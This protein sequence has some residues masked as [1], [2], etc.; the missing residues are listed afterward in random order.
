MESLNKL[1][2]PI[3]IKAGKTLTADVKRLPHLLIAGGGT[4]VARTYLSSMLIDAAKEKSPDTLRVL[5]VHLNSISNAL[6]HL[7]THVIEDENEAEAA[8]DWLKCEADRR[9]GLLTESG[10]YNVDMYNEHAEN[11]LFY[12]VAAIGELEKLT[13]RAKESVAMLAAKARAAGIYLLVSTEKP[14]TKVITGIIKANIP[15][16]IALKTETKAQSRLILDCFGAETLKKNELLFLPIGQSTPETL[17]FSV[18]SAGEIKNSL[19]ELASAY[20]PAGFEVLTAKAQ[21]VPSLAVQALEIALRYGTVSTALLQ[22]ALH[23]GYAKAAKL[24]DE[25]ENTGYIGEYRASK[26]REVL[27]T[28]TELEILI[29]ELGEI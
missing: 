11:K 1:I 2:C 8:L 3:G 23:I 28:K 15:S 29:K 7:L 13:K 14:D 19:S 26:P 25:M 17:N 9:F 20:P 27:L 21:N 10:T 22:R 16:R 24:I 4:G 12:I 18:P 5:A 6:P